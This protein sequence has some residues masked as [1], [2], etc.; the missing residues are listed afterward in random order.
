[1]AACIAAPAQQSA[2][3]VDANILGMPS[4]SASTC[5]CQPLTAE[6][7]PCRDI[8]AQIRWD[9]R[10]LRKSITAK[11]M[12]VVQAAHHMARRPSI[13]YDACRRRSIWLSNVWDDQHLRL[14]LRRAQRIEMD[15][16]IKRRHCY[17][18]PIISCHGNVGRRPSLEV[19]E[20]A[21]Q[22]PD[23]CKPADAPGK[24]SSTRAT[25]AHAAA[26]APL[27]S[28][29]YETSIKKKWVGGIGGRTCEMPGTIPMQDAANWTAAS[30]WLCCAQVRDADPPAVTTARLQCQQDGI[31]RSDPPCTL[32][33]QRTPQSRS[34][35]QDDHTRRVAGRPAQGDRSNPLPRR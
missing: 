20:E 12:V 21:K 18:C 1:M 27:D 35:A 9:T 8:Q 3:W 15:G 13:A 24:S 30:S 11:P 19:L 14:C 32:S 29:M 28:A 26:V 31:I 33:L 6:C 34:R 25:D 5:E 23:A 22:A 7:I 4:R 10:L 17:L 2:T 16:R